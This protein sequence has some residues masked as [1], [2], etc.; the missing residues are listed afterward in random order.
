[1]SDHPYR[2]PSV[3]PPTRRSAV[4]R[5]AKMIAVVWVLAAGWTLAVAFEHALA[6]PL[7]G[8]AIALAI[9]I[10]VVALNAR[11]LAEGEHD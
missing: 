5:T 1:M 9:G 7:T 4:T 3:A 8:L 2:T 11:V 6:G 10:P